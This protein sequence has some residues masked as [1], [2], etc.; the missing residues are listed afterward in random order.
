VV[1]HDHTRKVKHDE[2]IAIEEGDRTVSVDKGNQTILVKELEEEHYGKQL[3]CVGGDRTV[4]VDGTQKLA[5]KKDRAV[6]VDG[7]EKQ[8][9]KGNYTLTVGEAGT[10]C[11]LSFTPAGEIELKCPFGSITMGAS[12][13]TIKSLGALTLVGVPEVDIN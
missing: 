10:G 2:G 13:I 3:L 8:E 5:V 1:G 7:S 12:G 11:S 6:A 4:E 9:V